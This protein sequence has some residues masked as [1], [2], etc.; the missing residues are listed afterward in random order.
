MADQPI[1]L[2][3]HTLR[4]TQMA[5][6]TYKKGRLEGKRYAKFTFSIAERPGQTATMNMPWLPDWAV[7]QHKFR[8]MFGMTP[9]EFGDWCRERDLTSAEEKIDALRQLVARFEYT[10]TV[11]RNGKFFNVEDVDAQKRIG[12]PPGSV[13]DRIV[14]LI[15][16]LKL[17]PTQVSELCMEEFGVDHPRKLDKEMRHV[18]AELLGDLAQRQ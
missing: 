6:D 15:K 12:P 1:D 7:F 14:Q 3:P 13:E 18:L 2:G 11:V 8:V 16:K 17:T 9:D 10:A 5:F 4:V